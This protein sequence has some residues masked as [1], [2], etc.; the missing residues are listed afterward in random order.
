MSGEPHLSWF[1][2][3]LKLEDWLKKPCFGDTTWLSC[4]LQRYITSFCFQAEL[5]LINYQYS[6][7]IVYLSIACWLPSRGLHRVG[8]DWSDLAAIST[9][10]NQTEIRRLHRF[11]RVLQKGQNVLLH[12]RFFE[13]IRHPICRFLSNKSQKQRWDYLGMICGP[14]FYLIKWFTETYMCDPKCS[15]E[16]CNSGNIAS[17]VGEGRGQDKIK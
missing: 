11:L 10:C 16:C 1:Q 15:C 3:M 5:H 2:K 12:W 8:H 6:S 9:I 4:P 14:A 13:E 17:L 7:I